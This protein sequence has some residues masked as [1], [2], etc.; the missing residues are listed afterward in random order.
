[1]GFSFAIFTDFE[2][3]IEWALLGLDKLKEV[4]K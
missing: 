2:S 1:V 3:A 4:D